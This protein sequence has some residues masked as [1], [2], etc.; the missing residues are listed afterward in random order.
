MSE[1]LNA[2]KTKN[3][4]ITPT[5]TWSQAWSV[6]EF[7]RVAWQAYLGISAD[8]LN[9]QVS[10]TPRLPLEW[11]TGHCFVP[12]GEGYLKVEWNEDAVSREKSGINQKIKIDNIRTFKCSWIVSSS[13]ENDLAEEKDF[14]ND[15]DSTA[16]SSVSRITVLFNFAN[17]S[18]SILL[19]AGNT[20]FSYGRILGM[21][22]YSLDFAVPN[23]EKAHSKV[24]EALKTKNWLLEIVK[25]NKFNGEHLPT[26]SSVR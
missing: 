12:L 2:Y 13:E 25:K 24:A 17:G 9:H 6:S 19:E 10:I 16:N 1:N 3:G 11:K 5:G 4:L 20:G 8:M 18:K 22:D 14:T 21:G 15:N 26:P 7:S 23:S